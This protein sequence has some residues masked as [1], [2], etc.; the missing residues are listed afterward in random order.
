MVSSMVS[1]VNTRMVVSCSR[2][3]R[4]FQLLMS[5]DSGTFSGSQKFP[6]SRSQTSRSFSSGM[7]FQLMALMGLLRDSGWLS[8]C[9]GVAAVS[10]FAVTVFVSSCAKHS[11]RHTTTIF[12]VIF[13]T[14]LRPPPP[15]PAT[16]P[17][18]YRRPTF[19]SYVHNLNLLQAVYLDAHRIN[20]I[21][22]RSADEQ[23]SFCQVTQAKPYRKIRPK[24]PPT[25]ELGKHK[26]IDGIVDS[27]L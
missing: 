22:M 11:I 17:D 8:R 27:W 24:C 19:R 1:P 25:S 12:T 5:L 26:S 2:A 4:V 6:V 20:H 9:A 15:L 13:N 21:E 14:P 23:R 18:A 3:L 16:L 7:V 10:F